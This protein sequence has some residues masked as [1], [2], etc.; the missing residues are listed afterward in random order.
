MFNSNADFDSPQRWHYSD[1]QSSIWHGQL[2]DTISELLP[3][4][5]AETTG[6][7]QDKVNRKQSIGNKDA[8]WRHCVFCRDLLLELFHFDTQKQKRGF[9]LKWNCSIFVL[10][11]M[12]FRSSLRPPP[13]AFSNTQELHNSI[14][15]IIP[16]LLLTCYLFPFLDASVRNASL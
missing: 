10:F 12:N 7:C 4:S 14:K 3:Q 6:P 2:L 8:L 1:I 9:A 15:E 13:I 16:L 5:R 11:S